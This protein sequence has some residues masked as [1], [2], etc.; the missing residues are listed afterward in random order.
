[1][2]RPNKSHWYECKMWKRFKRC[3][4]DKNESLG[5]NR[6]LNY[7]KQS[8]GHFCSFTKEEHEAIREFKASRGKNFRYD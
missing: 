2:T 5:L 3:G 1:M 4:A 8:D 6:M 7:K